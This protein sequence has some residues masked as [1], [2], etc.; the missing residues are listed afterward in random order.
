MSEDGLVPVGAALAKARALAERHGAVPGAPDPVQPALLDEDL[1]ADW[2]ARLWGRR[3]P[4]RF[5][6]ARIG[7][8]PDGISDEVADW[9]AEDSPQNLVLL[10]PVGTGKTWAAVAAARQWCTLRWR[11]LQHTPG[12]PSLVF[13]PVVELLD[14]MRPGGQDQLGRWAL[15]CPLLILDDMGAERA[16]EWAGERLYGI[17]NRRW[18]DELP[19]IVTTNV[20]AEQLSDQLGDRV[21]SRLAG[22]ALVL[23]MT[24]K[25]RRRTGG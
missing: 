7:Q 13:A 10:G 11:T 17:V 6:S 21:L 12:P 2:L 5:H 9:C 23:R 22:D 8:L 3:I 25:D 16:T 20:P 24:G 18:L 4:T 14:D 19:T 1:A 15:A